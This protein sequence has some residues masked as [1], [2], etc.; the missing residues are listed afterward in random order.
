[1]KVFSRE[2][3][4]S[5]MDKIAPLLAEERRGYKW[6]FEC[7]GKTKEE[8][9]ALGYAITGDWMEEK[10]MGYKEKQA[11]WL[12]AN[13]LGEGSRVYVYR[14][15]ENHEDGWR[16]RWIELLMDEKVGKVAN[17]MEI[18]PCSLRVKVG[19][20]TYYM[21]YTALLPVG[22]TEFEVGRRYKY[23]GS[24]TA[25]YFSSLNIDPRDATLIASGE[26]LM[27]EKFE[28][29]RVKF[30]TTKY[31]WHFKGNWQDFVAMPEKDYYTELNRWI[32]THGLK[33]GDKVRVLRSPTLEDMEGWA[34]NWEDWLDEYVGKAFTVVGFDD[35]DNDIEVEFSRGVCSYVPYTVLEKVRCDSCLELS[36]ALDAVGIT[37]ISATLQGN[38]ITIEVQVEKGTFLYVPYTVL[39][40]VEYD[41]YLE[42]SKVLDS[43][44]I[45]VLSTKVEGNHITI[46][47]VIR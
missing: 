24:K 12:K 16:Y 45:L 6:P 33:I 21:P 25:E 47:G 15:A 10:E 14:K 27:V 11:D 13:N 3:Y 38:R 1:M 43:V 39:E 23:V 28:N 20:R 35:E 41:I 46:E 17:I 19:D 44:G 36:K 32:K 30:T 22:V 5:V 18:R 7:D 9:I 34:C 37:A 40:K 4:L 26:E 8:C 2:K 29:D 42:L 31:P